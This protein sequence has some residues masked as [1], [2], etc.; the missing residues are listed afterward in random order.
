LESK[1]EN[2]FKLFY[3]KHD[4]FQAQLTE[5]MERVAKAEKIQTEELEKNRR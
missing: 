1:V 2:C 3:E 5:K 4:D